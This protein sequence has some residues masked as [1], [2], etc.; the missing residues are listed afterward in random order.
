MDKHIQNEFNLRRTFHSFEEAEEE[1]LLAITLDNE[2][3]PH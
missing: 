2:T 1:I 3:R